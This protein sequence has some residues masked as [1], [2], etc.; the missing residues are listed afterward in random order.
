VRIRSLGRKAGL[1]TRPVK[2]VALLGSTT[3]LRWEQ[4][5]EAL[6]IQLPASLPS[7]IASSFQIRF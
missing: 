5:D 2:T 1:E 3:P 6:V 7:K 4:T